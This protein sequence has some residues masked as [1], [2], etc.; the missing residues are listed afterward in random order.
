MGFKHWLGYRFGVCGT[1][2]EIGEW[3]W[4]LGYS[5]GDWG[6]GWELLGIGWEF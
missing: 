2:S 6:L 3:V 1:G 5:C 4:R